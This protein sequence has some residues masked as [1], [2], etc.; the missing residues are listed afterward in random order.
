MRTPLTP[1]RRRQ[2]LAACGT[3]VLLALVAGCGSG[4]GTPNASGQAPQDSSQNGQQNGQQTQNGRPPGAN[5]KVAA[6][7]GSTAQVQSQLSGQVAVTWTAS[8]TFTKQ[9]AV[10]LSA[11]KAGDCVMVEPTQTSAS[12]GSGTVPTAITAKAVRITAPVNGSCTPAFGGNGGGPQTQQNGSGPQQFEGPPPSGAGG[13]APGDGKT[14]FRGFGAFG[15][16]SDVT[17][18]GFKVATTM[19]TGQGSATTTTDVTVTV[20]AGTTYTTMA[21]GTAADVKVGLCVRADGSTDNTGAVTAR[22]IAVTPP[23]N[24]QCGAMVFQRDGGPGSN[25]GTASSTGMQES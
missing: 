25:S 17:A 18:N 10:K 12:S 22:T 20:T 14:R 13:A 9:V 3:G 23:A 16:V 24:G 4:S 21:K 7:D 5:G 11:V 8:T 6:V 19:P 2:V 1:R 15:K